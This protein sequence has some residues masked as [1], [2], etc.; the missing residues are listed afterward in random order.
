MY[1]G[2]AAAAVISGACDMHG[3]DTCEDR[4]PPQTTLARPPAVSRKRAY[5]TS[6][7]GFGGRF[8]ADSRR[9]R[10]AER[11]FA[12]N[13]H[14]KFAFARQT[15]LPQLSRRR[16]VSSFKCLVAT[17]TVAARVS[18]GNIPTQFPFSPGLFAAFEKCIAQPAMDIAGGSCSCASEKT[19]NSSRNWTLAGEVAHA[20]LRALM[21]FP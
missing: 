1:S 14:G 16:A 9:D 10:E 18:R 2:R 6:R 12:R 13:R 19:K 8:A 4:A 15:P 20:A 3:N 17:G 5:L 11:K 7:R 21:A